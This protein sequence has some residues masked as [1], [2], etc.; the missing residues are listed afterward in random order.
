MGSYNMASIERKIRQFENSGA[1]KRAKKE[2]VARYIEQGVSKTGAGSLLTSLPTTKVMERIGGEFVDTVCRIARGHGVPE[3]VMEHLEG[4]RVGD[5]Q[6]LD[7]CTYSVDLF[8]GGD[9]SRPSLRPDDYDGVYNIVAVFNNGY[10]KDSIKYIYGEWHNWFFRALP[11]REGLHFLEAAAS[12]INKK[13][14]GRYN[15]EI[16]LGEDY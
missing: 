4:M 13:Y 15:I 12:E 5:P 8:V 11:K 3:S 6:K 2:C 10:S 1:G 14:A 9:T 16:L 7:E